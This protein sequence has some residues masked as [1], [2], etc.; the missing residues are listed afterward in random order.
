MCYLYLNDFAFEIMSRC[1]YDDCTSNV[2]R[3]DTFISRK[4]YDDD[5]LVIQ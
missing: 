4:G 3:I 1:A 5:L 2:T